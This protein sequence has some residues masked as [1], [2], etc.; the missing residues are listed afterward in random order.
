MLDVNELIELKQMPVIFYQLETIGKEIDRQIADVDKM[1]CTDENKQDV[2]NRRTEINN[3]TKLMEDKRK[4]IKKRILADYEVFNQKYEEEI[5]SK[6]TYASGVLT[7]KINEIESE[8]KHKKTQELIRFAQEHIKFANLE[9]IVEPVDV[10]PT[11]TLSASE[12]SLKEAIKEQLVEIAREV[13]LIEV[14]SY[15][16]EVLLEYKK[17]FDY[18]DARKIVLER[19]KELEAIAESIKASDEHIQQEQKIVEQVEEIIAPMPIQAEKEV[20]FEEMLEV[21]FTVWGY[22]DDI[23]KIR[24]FIQELGLKYE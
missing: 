11:V 20:E 9:G 23:T 15:P 10:I 24:K 5:K 6:L 16:D 21:S 18:L 8:Q 19:H 14:E 12:K 4:E 1:E 17:S 2:K 3:L 13:A 7:D 22:K